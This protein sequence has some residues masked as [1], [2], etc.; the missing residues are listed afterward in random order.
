MKNTV[1][2]AAFLAA[3]AMAALAL[4]GCKNS[5][6]PGETPGTP[7]DVTEI[8]SD[9]D[10]A[11]KTITLIWKDP[12]DDDFDHV[13]VSYITNDGTSDSGE[14]AAVS[15]AKGIQTFTLNDADSTVQYYRFT[16]KSVDVLG[17]TSGGV[18][19]RVN[20]SSSAPE[21]PEGFVK[22]AGGT[23]DGTETLAPSSSVF[24]SG[25]SLKIADLYVSDH[26]VTQ[27]EYETYCRYGSS[28]P[29]VA[30]GKGD[31]YP[32]YYVNWYDAVVYC[33]LRSIAESLIP[34]YSINNETDP[35]KWSGRKSDSGSPAKYCGPSSNNP[36]WNSV[37]FNESADGYRLPTQAEWEYIARGGNKDTF[38]Y[39]GSG[40]A[41][42]VAWY[43]ENSESKTHEVKQKKANSLGIYD[44]SGNVW[45]WCWDWD[46]T[47]TTGTPADGAASGSSRV[48][49]G[50]SWYDNANNA[51]VSIRGS[52]NPN[53]RFNYYGFRVVRN[54]S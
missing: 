42:D 17:N 18:V 29:S 5:A 19:K 8:S 45:E 13:L 39:S 16:L 38:T 6:V 46:S 20:V 2:T 37:N 3:A 54:A 15:V 52:N 43:K 36:T 48:V 35:S 14:S 22:V 28:S 31:N 30:C 41:G 7:A 27:K 32:A 23:F 40:T 10:S 33:N 47:V 49:R 51:A 24:I 9:Y 1:K 53:Y 4:F 11:A 34:A 50:G 26:E 25:R 12:E 44:M 21:I